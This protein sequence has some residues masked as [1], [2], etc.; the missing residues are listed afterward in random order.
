[1]HFN[2]YKFLLNILILQFQTQYIIMLIVSLYYKTKPYFIQHELFFIKVKIR[3][4]NYNI[5][6][7]YI[8]ELEL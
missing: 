6:I 4:N 5:I 3:V 7:T 1:M 8:K 2:I